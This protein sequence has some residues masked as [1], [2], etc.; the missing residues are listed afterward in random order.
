MAD[1]ESES[2]GAGEPRRLRLLAASLLLSVAALG[3]T[4]GVAEVG[5]R[6]AGFSALHDLYS[7]PSLFWVHDDDLGWVHER[8]AA[9]TYVGP[10][11]FPIE[12]ETPIRINPQ[13]LRG[14]DIG[15]KAADEY[16][17]L[18]LGDSVVAAFEVAYEATFVALLETRLSRRLDIPVRVINAGVRGYGTDQELIWY[19]KEGRA[20]DADLVVLVFST[21]DFV[22]NVTLH[23]MRRPF[24]KGAFAL[25]PGEALQPVGRPVPRFPLCSAWMLGAEFEPVRIDGSINRAACHLQTR[26]ADRSALFTFVAQALARMPGLVTAL[27]DLVFPSAQKRLGSGAAPRPRVAGFP[28]VAGGSG[29]PSRAQI[30]GPLSTALVRRLAHS[31]RQDGSDFFTML[32]PANLV[33]MDAESLLADGID[34]RQVGVPLHV[35]PAWI[36]FKNDSHFNERGHE[37]VARALRPV[38]EAYARRARPAL[39]AGAPPESA[40]GRITLEQL[41]AAQD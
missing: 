10:R 16:R 21:N 30:E 29:P 40:P 36:T 25:G 15:P 28:G 14:P 39:G 32:R 7:K 22:N 41:E 37:I 4:C 38:V 9:G 12:F 13:G 33:R 6:L 35:D 8:G 24:G 3:L 11:P 18:V 19:E 31:A 2:P 23:R 1:V 27:K 20:L 17:V 5:F 26:A 34:F